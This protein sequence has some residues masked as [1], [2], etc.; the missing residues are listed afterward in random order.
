MSQRVIRPK[1]SLHRWELRCEQV[2]LISKVGSKLP[3]KNWINCGL[4]PSFA[5]KNISDDSASE[6]K[7]VLLRKMNEYHRKFKT[8]LTHIFQEGKDPLLVYKDLNR[9]DWPAFIAIRNSPAFK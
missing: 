8:N 5:S 4:G 7:N 3:P 1:D 9:E 2:F 6:H